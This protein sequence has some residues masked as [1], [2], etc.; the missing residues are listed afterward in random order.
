[1][2][3]CVHTSLPKRH[4]DLLCRFCCLTHKQ[5]DRSCNGVCI[6]YACDDAT[7]A[8]NEVNTWKSCILSWSCDFYRAMLCIRGTIAMGLCPSVSVSVA[9]RSSTKTA[10]RR[11]TQT[12]PHDTPGT[13]V[14]WCQRSPRNST[15]VLPTK[16]PNTGG[17]VKIG[18]FRQITGYV[19]KTVKDGH[20]VPIK[21]A[22]LFLWRYE[23]VRRIGKS[24][25]C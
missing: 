24:D 8:V 21:V 19:S 22:V 20:I 16:A 4:L 12:T 9:S 17:V 10:K 11:I 1:M 3:P 23:P 2:V 5:N 7:Q 18:D 15:G 14:F 25:D 6:C 13:L